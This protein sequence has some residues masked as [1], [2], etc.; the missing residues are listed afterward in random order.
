M[1]PVNHEI[2]QRLLKRTGLYQPPVDKTARYRH[3]EHGL[4]WFVQEVIGANPTLYQERILNA[5]QKYRRVAV[6]GPHGLGKTALASWVVLWAVTC[7]EGVKAPV[8][9]SV[10]RQVSE[11]LF[12]EIRMWARK[13]NWAKIG[14]SMKE[15]R[16]VLSYAIHTEKGRAFGMSSDTPSAIEGAHADNL[17]YVFDEAKAIPTDF[18]DAAEGAFSNAGNGISQAYWLAISTPGETSG[19]FYEIHNRKKGLEDWHVEHVTL[20]EAIAAGRVSRA[21]ADS[22]LELWGATSTPYMNRVLGEFSDSDDTNV[23]P[24]RWVEAAIE[25]GR[26]CDGKGE[27]ETAYGV[28]PAR[29]GEDRTAIAKLVGDVCEY[30]ERHAKEDTMQTTGRVVAKLGANKSIPVGVD[31][32]GIGAGV[33]DRLREL[34]YNV[35]GVNVAEGTD[36]TDQSG[37]LGFANLRS[38]IWWRLRERLDPANDNLLALPDDDELIGDLTAPKYG[39]NSRGKIQVESKDEIRKRIGRSTDSADALGNA[40][41]VQSSGFWMLS[42]WGEE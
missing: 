25:R 12:P 15:D 39:Y 32:I 29:F 27:G 26:E 31:V 6:R 38:A 3:T 13:A 36:E 11:Y 9:A 42:E 21:W 7:L 16:E 2:A 5:I 37:E 1:N 28:D 14:A 30:I 18:W 19:R 41:Y 23:I 8:M 10:W 40:V 34:E 35:T 33:V 24:L 17:V 4:L 20:E 22:R